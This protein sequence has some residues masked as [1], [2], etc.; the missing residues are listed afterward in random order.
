MTTT[1]TSLRMRRLLGGIVLS[2]ASALIALGV[3]AVGHAD[4]GPTAG[5]T[6]GCEVIH[7]G[8]FGN[9]RRKVCDGPQ[10]SDGTW[11]RTRTVFTP[12]R[13]TPVNCWTNPSHPE[14]GPICLGGYRPETV[15]TQETYPVAP[16]TVLPDE[17]GWLPPYTYNVF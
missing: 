4:P 5:P 16:S 10:Q 1:S 11:Q 13:D 6:M 2:G 14:N 7:W 9:D 17:P 15:Q 8:A 12:E 3:P